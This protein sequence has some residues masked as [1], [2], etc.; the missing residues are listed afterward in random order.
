MRFPTWLAFIGVIM[1]W[2]VTWIV[3]K[4]Q[5]G[6]V[7]AAW[8]VCYRFLLAGIV[9]WVICLARG[10]VMAATARQHVRLAFYGVFQFSLNFLCVY[11]A[12]KHIPS[13]LVAV[14]F[15]LMAPSNALLAWIVLKQRPAKA[16]VL[17]ALM[18]VGGVVLLFSDEI[19]SFNW[20]DAGALSLGLATAGMASASLGNIIPA[21]KSMRARSIHMMNAWGMIYGACASALYASFQAGPPRFS[22]E[23][24]YLMG[25]AY[26]SIFGSV[27]AFTFYVSVI[28]SWGVSRAG[29]TSVLIPLVA[30]GASTLFEGYQ[31]TLASGMGAALAL[32]GTLVAIIAKRK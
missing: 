30:L 31:W 18:G 7:P 10:E 24:G 23:Q 29:Y 5:F 15:S 17:G 12:E 19:R 6:L 4:S 26:L 27:L 21:L 22:L 3:I 13:G 11:E 14:A 8:S 9:L 28:R 20:Q 32:G 1:I 2:G 25:L 16:I